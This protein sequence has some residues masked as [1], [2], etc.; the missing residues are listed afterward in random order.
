MVLPSALL[1]R[2]AWH[3]AA[4]ALA[5]TMGYGWRA[6]NAALERAAVEATM[7]TITDE[8]KDKAKTLEDMQNAYNA[9]WTL[10]VADDAA[11]R[12]SINTADRGRVPTVCAQ[13]GGGSA[14]DSATRLGTP[15]AA[16]AGRVYH[17]TQDG[18]DAAAL[19]QETAELWES[20]LR[21]CEALT[22]PLHPP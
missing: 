9:S 1:T 21:R 7:K 3:G 13:S 14:D 8:R 6:H 4:L 12:L 11:R 19:N 15:E 2:I 20:E 17:D 10:R 5:F 18:L 16:N 22:A